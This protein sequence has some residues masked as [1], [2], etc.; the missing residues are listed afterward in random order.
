MQAVRI[1]GMKEL[2]D[3][4][5]RYG[6][7]GAEALNDA[8]FGAGHIIANAIQ[9]AAPVGTKVHVPVGSTKMGYVSL[10][11]VR[12]PGNLKRSIVVERVKSDLGGNTGVMFKVGPNRGAGYYAY[13]L[14]F[15]TSRMRHHS[16]MRPAYDSSHEA[17]MKE[18]AARAAKKI[19][20]GEK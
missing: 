16:F 15:G 1:T 12:Y 18:A 2:S 11:K 17:A 14:E 13:F 20:E 10:K 19:A 5:K 6:P 4:L 3:S 8:C 9:A 7:L